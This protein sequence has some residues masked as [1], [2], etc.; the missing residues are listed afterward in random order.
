MLADFAVLPLDP[1]D[2]EPAEL[3]KLPVLATVVG[4][5]Q[6]WSR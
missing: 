6:R 4:G 5:E 2:V 3:R 1:L